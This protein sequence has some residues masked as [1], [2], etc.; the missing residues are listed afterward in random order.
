MTSLQGM[1]RVKRARHGVPK[2]HLYNLRKEVGAAY[3]AGER[4]PA[5]SSR[6]ESVVSSE[7]ALISVPL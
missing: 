7:M 2:N 1:S 6:V 5:A 4:N 3:G